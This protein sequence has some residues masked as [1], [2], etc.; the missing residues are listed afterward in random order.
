MPLDPRLHVNPS[1]AQWR[2]LDGRRQLPTAVPFLDAMTADSEHAG[3]LVNV[4]QVV[5][6]GA[7]G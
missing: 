3:Q 1:P 2:A 7:G 6:H 5:D 4:D